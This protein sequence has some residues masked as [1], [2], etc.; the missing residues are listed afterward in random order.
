MKKAIPLIAF[1]L[2]S[3]VSAVGLAEV[4]AEYLAKGPIVVDNITIIDGLGNSPVQGRDIVI[5]EGR[6]SVI[7]KAGESA[8]P[9][10]ATIVDGEGLTAMP[11]LIDL[12]YHLK[13]GWSG[14]NAMQ[15]K[16][17]PSELLTD[18]AIQ[19]SLAAMLYSG[20]KTAYDMGST[21]DWIVKQRDRINGGE[22]VGPRY[23]IAGVPFSQEPTGWDAAVRGETVGEPEPDALSTKIDTQDPDELGERLDRYS[24]DGISLIKLYSGASALAASFLIKEAKKRNIRTV[25]DLWQL[26]M[27]AD[28]MR[29]TGLDGW[30]HASPYPISKDALKWMADN[31]KF[32]IATMVIGDNHVWFASKRRRR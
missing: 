3:F 1:L 31:D 2:L 11:G 12:H 15:D 20:V 4:K 28:W 5:E 21:H 30:A 25:A 19:Q 18:P 14:G 17:P 26:N 16:Y 24:S 9:A 29:M 22:I 8:H 10:N 32:I 7:S 13:G 27:D 23:F 6:I